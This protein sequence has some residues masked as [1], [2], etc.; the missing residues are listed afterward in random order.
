[1]FLAFQTS[2]N[3][4]LDAFRTIGVLRSRFGQHKWKVFVSITLNW[5]QSHQSVAEK[6]CGQINLRFDGLE[7]P[8]LTDV[9]GA[10]LGCLMV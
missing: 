3:H 8:F 4:K 1:M 5:G 6:L 2:D 10:A 7:F 9:L